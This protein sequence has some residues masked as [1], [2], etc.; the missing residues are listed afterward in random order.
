MPRGES[1]QRSILV[2]GEPDHVFLLRLWVRLWRILRKAVRRDEAPVLGLQPHAPVRRR[3]VADVGDRRSTDL[4]RRRHAPSHRRQF[5][6]SIGVANDRSR[7]VRKHAGHRR[8]IA[9]VAVDHSEQRN[10]GGLIG[11]YRIEITDD[12]LLPLIPS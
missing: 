10:D 4:W 3:R 5:A 2:Q 11:R 12:R 8:Q 6:T 9:D 1:E 7:I